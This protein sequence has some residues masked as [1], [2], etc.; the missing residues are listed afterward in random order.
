MSQ[1]KALSSRRTSSAARPHTSRAQARHGQSARR[2]LPVAD[3]LWSSKEQLAAYQDR[4]TALEGALSSLR[5]QAE[6]LAVK[7]G[8]SRQDQ[9]R[10]EELFQNTPVP[11]VVHDAAGYVIALNA[12]AASLL[13]LS[14][15][16][17][18]KTGLARHFSE[19]NLLRWFK[20][21]RACA[22]SRK[23]TVSPLEIR[24]HGNDALKVEFHTSPGPKNTPTRP[25]RFHTLI[26][27]ITR[28]RALE[29]A[30]AQ[31]QQ[32]YHQLVDM[33]EGIV[34]EADPQ[35]LTITFVNGYAE[36]LLG[37]PLEGWSR[38][39]FWQNRIFVQ[40]RERVLD[41]LNRAQVDRKELRIDYRVVRADR[42]LVWL[43]DCIRS[44]EQ[45]GRSKLLGVAIDITERRMA[46]EQLREAHSSLEQSVAERTTELR[47]TVADL[48]GFSYS[49]SH[50]LRA[51]I[52]AMQGYAALV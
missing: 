38:P 9:A 16:S 6:S 19:E 33:V 36:R 35:D 21:M 48:E 11:Y 52:R 27:D 5:V 12:S 43:H 29:A 31:K 14:H 23:L 20:H 39:G 50:D 3:P 8:Q 26:V 40:D 1:E 41:A 7:L 30:L 17:A 25:E 28:R 34:W 15:R 47:H 42:N 4:V 24:A 13:G 49:L 45:D 10:L 32:Y 46:E 51:P 18:A 37:F 44:I 22:S 2:E